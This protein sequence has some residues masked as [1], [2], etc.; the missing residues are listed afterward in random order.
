MINCLT[1]V[2][3]DSV[4][5][6]QFCTQEHG[7]TTICPTWHSAC[8]LIP[9]TA[10]FVLSCLLLPMSFAQLAFNQPSRGNIFEAL[11]K[12]HL[13]LESTFLNN[14][15]TNDYVVVIALVGF[16]SF[17]CLIFMGIVLKCMYSS[18]IKKGKFKVTNCPE[19][20]LNGVMYHYMFNHYRLTFSH[21][22]SLHASVFNV[23]AI[24]LSKFDLIRTFVS[25]FVLVFIVLIRIF[26]IIRLPLMVPRFIFKMLN[27]FCLSGFLN[28]ILTIALILPFL[29]FAVILYGCFC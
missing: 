5:A 26:P 18:Q 21:V 4:I 16:V 9:F 10:L 22:E 25:L 24:P 27:Q 20:Q 29:G 13:V 1:Q 23:I 17:M 2:Q 12:R 11:K 3:R 6:R 7:Q 8:Q 15:E 19:N 14:I 28:F